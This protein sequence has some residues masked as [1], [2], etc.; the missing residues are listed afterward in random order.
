MLVATANV[1]KST[2]YCQNFPQSAQSWNFEIPPKI[3]LLVF[4]KNKN[5]AFIFFQKQKILRVEEAV[6][7]VF[8][9]WIFNPRIF[10]MLFLL[11]KNG[12]CMWIS[13]YLIVQND[14]F[15]IVPYI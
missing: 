8:S 9:L 11:S 14:V 5:W 10:H 2:Q 3:E 15:L 12:L 6:E 7:H 1:G 4:F 13:A